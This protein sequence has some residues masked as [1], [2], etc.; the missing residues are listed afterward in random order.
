MAKYLNMTRAVAGV[1][2]GAT[3]FFGA[4]SPASAQANEQC[5]TADFGGITLLNPEVPLTP[6]AP[7][8]LPAGVVTVTE[9]HAWDGYPSRVDVTQGSEIWEVEF[10]GA[11]GSVVGVSARTEDLEDRV[12]EAHRFGSLGDVTLS[13][14]AVS[15]RARHRPDF[16]LKARDSVRV[17]EI[18]VCFGAQTTTTTQPPTTTTTA[19][20]TTAPPP[21]GPTTIP[22]CPVDN[23]GNPIDP[24]NPDCPQPTTAPPPA[25][26]T[27]APPPAGPTTAPPPKGPSLPVTGADSTALLLGGM[28]FLVAGSTMVA[29]SRTR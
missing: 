16:D 4:I 21:A 6:E 28:W 22:P 9:A 11:D 27:T 17:S 13:E 25:G 8:A 24:T 29:Y 23:D 12:A 1:L 15:I 20:T 10:V 26:P 19:P 18:T 2:V 3:A 14:P 5:L 7:M